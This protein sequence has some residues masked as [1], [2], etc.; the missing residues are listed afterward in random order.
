MVKLHYG[1]TA[2]RH[3]SSVWLWQR[4]MNISCRP[5]VRHIPKG[6]SKTPRLMKHA[7]LWRNSHS[8]YISSIYIYNSVT[9]TPSEFRQIQS[10]TAKHFQRQTSTFPVNTRQRVTNY[11][12]ANHEGIQDRW[13]GGRAH[14]LSN[15]PLAAGCLIHPTRPIYSV[16]KANSQTNLLKTIQTWTTSHY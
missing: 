9:P 7:Y 1:P 14:K 11:R 8:I 10:A 2:D 6:G 12:T 5:A 16:L 4:H 13:S 3:I 15:Q